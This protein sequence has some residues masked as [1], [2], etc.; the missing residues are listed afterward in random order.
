MLK[1]KW[2]IQ[3]STSGFKFNLRRYTKGHVRLVTLPLVHNVL[4]AGTFLFHSCQS[5]FHRSQKPNIQNHSKRLT[6]F[7]Q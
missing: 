7:R 4:S 2:D 3:L 5:S 6:S 1:L